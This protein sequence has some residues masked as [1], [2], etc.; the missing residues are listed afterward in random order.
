MSQESINPYAPAVALET[1]SGVAGEVA[2][3]QRRS[4]ARVV[5]RWLLVCSFA[6]GPSFVLGINLGEN[7]VPPMVIGILCF[8]ALYVWA[9]WTTWSWPIRQ[10]TLTRRILMFTYITRVVI[11]IVFP[12]GM[13]VDMVAGICSMSIVGF[14][15]QTTNMDVLVPSDPGQM[16]F[17]T[18]LLTT[19]IQG[20]LLNLV[21]ALV[22]IVAFG[23][24]RLWQR[25]V[26]LAS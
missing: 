6:A 23:A 1:A 4:L 8:V 12:I 24:V 18:A 20:L 26:R 3:P 19:L 2:V 25:G 11:T 7:Q 17:L 14:A 10:S 16:T 22:A 15:F 9:D 13:V 5:V 21:L